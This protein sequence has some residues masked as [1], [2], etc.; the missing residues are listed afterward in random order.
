MSSESLKGLFVA[1]QADLFLCVDNILYFLYIGITKHKRGAGIMDDQQNLLPEVTGPKKKIK[2]WMIAVPVVAAV[3]I[4]AVC[5]WPTIMLYL[6]PRSVLASA[7]AN[8][9][10]QLAKRYEHSPSAA[11]TKTGLPFESNTVEM[12]MLLSFFFLGDLEMEMDIRTDLV[13]KAR[14][15]DMTVGLELNALFGAASENLDFSMYYDRDCAAFSSD[16]LLGDTTLGMTFDTLDEDIQKCQLFA[17]ADEEFII[18]LKEYAKSMRNS[19]S[20]FPV[21]GSDFDGALLLDGA[22][23]LADVPFEPGS[24][25]VSVN[26]GQVRCGTVT[27]YLDEEKLI[28]L[29]QFYLDSVAAD[30]AQKQNYLQ[31]QKITTDADA[32]WGAYIDSLRD[33][34]KT[35]FE[36]YDFR[37][38][39]INAIH[40]ENILQ[41][42]NSVSITRIKDNAVIDLELTINYGLNPQFDQLH[43]SGQ[44]SA[45]EN[46]VNFDVI[47]NAETTDQI[48]SQSVNCVAEPD[49]GEQI[50]LNLAYTWNKE[51]G[52]LSLTLDYPDQKGKE[53]TVKYKA[54]L[55]IGEDKM[56]LKLPNLDSLLPEM[57]TGSVRIND[58]SALITVTKGA[59]VT[60]PSYLNL[61][62]WT[63]EHLTSIMGE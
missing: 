17:N 62:Q 55:L 59:E 7:Y 22:A 14:Q 52:D 21:S 9:G 30:E 51:A 47:E 24:T 33:E 63:E 20:T 18:F 61:D 44:L 25:E 16:R 35:F 48:F 31:N 46:E 43:I 15:I 49:E 38:S 5:L 10:A 11:Y 34:V 12:D 4:A 23:L 56:E 53:K 36:E 19:F 60:K 41:T 27:V 57:E 3:L 32:K 54:N 39:S 29:A 28:K 6:S 42:G 45:E 8:T 13:Q 50:H 37:V 58:F 26:G 40:E 2:W 1:R